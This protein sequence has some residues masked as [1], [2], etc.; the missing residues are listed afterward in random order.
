MRESWAT[1]SSNTTLH[2]VRYVG[3]TSG[4][5]RLFWIICI[6]SAMGGY[7]YLFQD[8]LRAYISLPINTVISND[9]P[10]N[11]MDFPDLTIC[12]LN[13]IVKSK[14]D[15]G[16]D[17]PRFKMLNLDMAVCGFIRNISGNLTCG[18][19]LT[20]AYHKMARYIVQRCDE[21]MKNNILRALN[22]S[23]RLFNREDYYYRYGHDFHR[24]L[25]RHCT[26]GE[27]INP[28][29]ADDFDPV[30]T[31]K[32]L[33]HTFNVSRFANRTRRKGTKIHFAGGENGL[34]IILDAQSRETTFGD[35]S[36]GFR[37][38][39][40][41]QGTGV[42]RDRGFDANPGSHVL[43][44]LSP[45]IVRLSYLYFLSSLFRLIPS[46]LISSAG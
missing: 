8:S 45:K 17:D 21:S 1:F 46:R 24:M 4:I 13:T 11:G 44:V 5:R 32:G 30:M 39:V 40:S 34:S 36:V 29:I 26:Y 10:H 7:L 6:S 9:F 42:N 28:C 16:Y 22:T 38:V 20:C 19:A 23:S 14:N 18:Q 41:E 2:G 25:V 3:T 43:A 35:W 33:C 27:D 37:V 31:P 12:N 15:I